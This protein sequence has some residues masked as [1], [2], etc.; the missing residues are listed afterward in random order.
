MSTKVPMFEFVIDRKIALF[1]LGTAEG[2]VGALRAAAPIVAEIRD[3]LLRPEY[4]RI[5]ARRLGMDPTDVHAEVRRHERRRRH[6]DADG[7]RFLRCIRRRLRLRADRR[8]RPAFP[9]AQS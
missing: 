9:P 7:G 8:T 6:G 1:D 2:R 3:T 4:E 5:L